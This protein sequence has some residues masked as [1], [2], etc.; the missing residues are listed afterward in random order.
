MTTTTTP[1]PYDLPTLRQHWFPPEPTD[2]TVTAARTAQAAIWSVVADATA[3]LDRLV[4]DERTA[5]TA[6]VDQATDGTD[7]TTTASDLGRRSPVPNLRHH[8]DL[9]HQASTTVT[10]RLMSAQHTDETY[11]AWQAECRD[12]EDDWQRAMNSDDRTASLL[13]FAERHRPS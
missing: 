3:E 10:N 5:T 11:L 12:I 2:T 6:L 13:D 7:I 1:L 8:L 4:T 9:L